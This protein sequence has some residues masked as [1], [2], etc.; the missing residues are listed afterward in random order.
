V[1]T[2]IASA[3]LQPSIEKPPHEKP[4]GARR[5]LKKVRE[6]HAEQP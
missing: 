4:H 2:D 6:A 5:L 3:D 1:G